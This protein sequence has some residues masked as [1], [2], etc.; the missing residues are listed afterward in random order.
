VIENF[1]NDPRRFCVKS[2]VTASGGR[3]KLILKVQEWEVARLWVNHIRRSLNQ[4][5][6]CRQLESSPNGEHA[7]RHFKTKIEKWRPWQALRDIPYFDSPDLVNSMTGPGVRRG[8]IIYAKKMIPRW[9]QT[10][11][12]RWL[13]CRSKK[14]DSYLTLIEGKD[15]PVKSYEVILEELAYHVNA[16]GPADTSL[17][18]V[19]MRS[20][21]LGREECKGWIRVLPRG[22]WLPIS[23]NGRLL[24]DRVYETHL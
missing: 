24:L 16:F 14:G 15:L 22:L 4:L 13:P 5:Q 21:V 20:I 17:G 2:G 3:I 7:L 18:R 10:H 11:D 6:R 12:H 1:E 19:S 23:K 9:I 8:D